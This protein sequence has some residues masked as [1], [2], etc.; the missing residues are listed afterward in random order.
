[1]PST[2]YHPPS[3]PSLP[4]TMPFLQNRPRSPLPAP[5]T[6]HLAAHTPQPATRNPLVSPQFHIDQAEF[7]GVADQFQGAVKIQFVHDVGPV[8]FDGLGTDE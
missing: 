2:L 8:I 7:G 6:P 3:I 5:R 4:Y 1:M